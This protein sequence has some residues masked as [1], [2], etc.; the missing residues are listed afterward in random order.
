MGAPFGLRVPPPAAALAAALEAPR[1][2]V[3]RLALRSRISG[4]KTLLLRVFWMSLLMSRLAFAGN[5]VDTAKSN[6]AFGLDFYKRLRE[7]YSD[8]ANLMVSPLSAYLALSMVYNGA[9]KQTKAEIAEVLRAQGVSPEQL[10]RANKTLI[11]ILSSKREGIETKIAN[12]LFTNK[13]FKLKPA[14]AKQLSTAYLALIE[15][16]DFSDP[17]TVK[18]LNDWASKKTNG[19]ITTIAE[20]LEARMR[21]LLLNA[22]YFKG[23]WLKPF[24]E[25]NTKPE[26]FTKADGSSI[27]TPTMHN[28]G[29]FKHVKTEAFEAIELP[30]G[31]TGGVSMIVVLGD[32][33]P[34]KLD[35]IMGALKNSSAGRGTLSLPK[36]KHSTDMD[37]D[38]VL[39]AMGMKSAFTNDA[40]FKRM[41]AESVAIDSAFQKTYIEVN[42]KS[43]EAAAVTGFSYRMTSAGPN[44]PFDMKVDR[45]FFYAIRDNETN[46]LLFLGTVSDPS[47]E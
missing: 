18:Y 26:K 42:E 6:N 5:S 25:A 17:K 12:A 30:Y 37:I 41:S 7:A 15:T 23:I 38:K 28:S 22:T 31:K 45:P 44:E 33:G 27:E 21:A 36:W 24:P 16:K 43:T 13:G 35:E 47:K 8:K 1:E 46:A 34:D 9:D 29:E 40:N 19:K 20:K 14:F 39:I 2:A 4:M 3:T 11:K 10:N 32:K